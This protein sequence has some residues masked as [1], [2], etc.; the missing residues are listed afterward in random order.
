MQ[1]EEKSRATDPEDVWVRW[2][3]RKG[4]RKG[5]R[6]AARRQLTL[7]RSASRCKDASHCLFS[8][9]S[10]VHNLEVLHVNVCNY[11]RN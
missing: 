4:E 6:K 7:Q 9:S 1:G 2:E 5:E 8:F 10:E 11:E 3:G